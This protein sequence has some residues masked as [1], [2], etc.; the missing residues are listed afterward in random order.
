[1]TRKGGLGKGLEA[2]IPGGS[3][4]SPEGGITYVPIDQIVPNPLQPRAT[5]DAEGLDELAASIREHGVL[6]P[7]LV[8]PE[9]EGRYVL[10]AGE[11]RWRAARQAGL[12]MVPVLLRPASDV[13]RLALA[14]IEN[15]QRADLTPLEM[16]EAYRQL[17]EDFG[18]SHE[19]IARQVGKSRV[20]VTNT[21]RL[22]K[23]PPPVREA[24]AAGKISEGH[25]RALLGLSTAQA[26]VAVLEVVL[27]QNLSVR[28]TEM[29]VQ[30]YQ[31]QRPTSKGRSESPPETRDLEARLEERLGTRVML[32]RGKRG[33]SL[34]IRFYSD[35][36]L[37]TLLKV[38]LG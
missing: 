35:E 15:L 20:A 6:Q 2:L 3:G 26:Q 24:L 31:G 13:Q 14:L 23:L 22:L 29:L 27:R 28:Q 25:A 30:R 17:H 32:R 10:I 11:R 37:E 12:E 36:E 8:S 21:L 5:L 16:A 7:L 34:V 9:G 4:T 18:L 1:M 38:L 33:G 19:E